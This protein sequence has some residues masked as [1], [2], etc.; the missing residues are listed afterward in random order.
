MVLS[1]PNIQLMEMHAHSAIQGQYYDY[2]F[3]ARCVKIKLASFQRTWN[4]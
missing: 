4:A 1:H 3:A 2:Y